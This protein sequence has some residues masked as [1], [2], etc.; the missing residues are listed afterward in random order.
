MAR[1]QFCTLA[2]ALQQ[3]SRNESMSFNTPRKGKGKRQRVICNACL[4]MGKCINAPQI[5]TQ[6]A[7]PVR[8]EATGAALARIQRSIRC[9]SVQALHRKSATAPTCA[10]PVPKNSHVNM[11]QS[12]TECAERGMCQRSKQAAR[13]T[14]A[15][16]A[17]VSEVE[18]FAARGSSKGCTASAAMQA[19][20]F[21]GTGSADIQFSP[22]WFF[23]LARKG[24]VGALV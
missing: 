2:A 17:T 6:S 18:L 13:V 11:T 20:V 16:H 14:L 19:R 10:K 24:C 21:R 9:P 7:V 4:L 12:K 3:F 1:A 23:R 8:M 15:I 5:A 22:V